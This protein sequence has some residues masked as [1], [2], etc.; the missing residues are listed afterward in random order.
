MAVVIALLSLTTLAAVVMA[1]SPA[2][3]TLA[4]GRVA[5]RLLKTAAEEAR[6]TDPDRLQG[7]VAMLLAAAAGA[8]GPPLTCGEAGTSP[9]PTP[10]D[11]PGDPIHSLAQRPPL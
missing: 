11:L 8:H 7:A 4:R 6:R 1:C 10:A 2:G 5:R 9:T 3:H